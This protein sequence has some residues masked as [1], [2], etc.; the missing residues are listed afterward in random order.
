MIS[1]SQLKSVEN[2]LVDMAIKGNLDAIKF[3][4][5]LSNKKDNTTKTGWENYNLYN[6]L[7]KLMRGGY[8]E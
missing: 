3:V 6:S 4:I 2:T 5:S 7:E 8:S 1:E